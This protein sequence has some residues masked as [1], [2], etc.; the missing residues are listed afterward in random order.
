MLGAERRAGSAEHPVLAQLPP[1]DQIRNLFWT[2]EPVWIIKVASRRTYRAAHEGKLPP[3]P[4][5]PETIL[6]ARNMYRDGVRVRDICA[7]TGFSVGALYHHLDG[8]S[9]PGSAAPRLPRRRA[10][11]GD[12]VAPMPS[13]GRKKL[14][15]RLW[16]AAERQ[17]RKIEFAL[18]WGHQRPEER[19]HD[20]QALRELTRI[21]RDL[22]AL[23]DSAA[24][25]RPVVVEHEQA[26]AVDGRAVVIS[27]T[28]AG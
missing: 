26:L 15:A 10:V 23:E 3:A 7:A 17:A 28:K 14:A 4:T 27:R 19:A 5:S 25:S 11:A 8:L 18:T 1:R 16:R 20:L 6:R 2:A 13:R 21:L 12:A 22:S 9:L 24:R